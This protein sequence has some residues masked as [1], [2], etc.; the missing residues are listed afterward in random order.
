[1]LVSRSC[2]T[3][4]WSFATSFCKFAIVVRRSALSLRV[5]ASSLVDTSPMSQAYTMI[6]LFCFE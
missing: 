4:M 5:S 1:M 3:S 6:S 2:N